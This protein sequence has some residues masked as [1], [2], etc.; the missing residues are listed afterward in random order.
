MI[1]ES[2]LY[3]AGQVREFDRR[4]IVEHGIAGYELMQ[5]AARACWRQVCA[6]WPAALSLL[7]ICGRGN[8]GGDGYEIARLARQ[9]GWGVQVIAP[10]GAPAQDGGD[11]RRAYEAWLADSAAV[12]SPFAAPP[13][14]AVDV[15]VDALFGTGLTRRLDATAVQVV[16]AI[17][18]ARANGARVVA[19]DVPSGLDAS[20]GDA[21]D[22]LCVQADLTV[23]F[24]GRKLGLHTAQGPRWTGEVGFDALDVPDAVFAGI[25]PLARLQQRGDLAAA[26]PR[27]A[28]TAH[29]GDHGHVVVVGGNRGMGGAALLAAR[30]ALRAGAGLVSVV[31]RGEHTA[32][33]TAAQPELMCHADDDGNELHA[34]LAKADVIACG[35]GLGT[36]AWA[37][38]LWSAVRDARKPAVIDADALNLLAAEPCRWPGAVLTPHPGEAARLLARDT[39]AIQTDRLGAL[40]ELERRYGAGIVLKGA[41]TLI[42]GPPAALCPFGNPGMAVGGMGDILSGIIAAFMGQGLGA[43]VAAQ[44]GVLAHALAGDQAARGGERGLL[45]GD[46]VAILREV[47]NP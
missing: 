21:A 36:D 44:C 9:A 20:T 46:V 43:P 7:V 8:N 30:A 4:A 18:A 19:V 17:G 35:P 38:R 24:I 41:G 26:L 45:P 14:P 1:A 40:H 33:M 29:K 23:S 15:V 34:L 6:R 11:A 2:F 10:Y 47:V 13:L 16:N 5:R 27:R 39:R 31:T 22:G 12:P 25:T 3:D 32:A 37:R 28:R 42:S